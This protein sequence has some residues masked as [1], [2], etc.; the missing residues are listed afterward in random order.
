M[1]TIQPAAPKAPAQCAK[2]YDRSLPEGS[3][4]QTII[5]DRLSF[6]IHKRDF[7]SFQTNVQ[8]MKMKNFHFFTTAFHEAYIPFCLD[9]GPVNLGVV[10]KFCDFMKTKLSKPLLSNR[11]L[12]YCFSADWR[13]ASNACF[14]LAAYLCIEMKSTPEEALRP[15]GGMVKRCTRPFRDA[16]FEP[17]DFL[18]TLEDCI[19]GLTKALQ[20]QWLDPTTFDLHDYAKWDSPRNGDLHQI[21]PKLIAFRGPVTLS[22]T[23]SGG[24]MHEKDLGMPS[25]P[26]EY[27]VQVL[28]NMGV[29]AIVRLTESDTYDAKVFESAGIRV[30]ELFFSD[31]STPAITL[32]DKFL[33]VCDSEPGVVA[34]HCLAGLGRTGTMIG[35]WMIRKYGW[36]AKEAVGWL[37]IVRPGSVIGPQQH[38]LTRVELGS[39]PVDDAEDTTEDDKTGDGVEEDLR[40]KLSM[41]I[42]EG[43]QRKW[44]LDERRKGVWVL[45]V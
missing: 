44:D 3:T 43:M 4:I 7:R 18:L 13:L 21:C 19:R 30:H 32:L 2:H 11:H 17:S 20:Q 24:T 8:R 27:Y 14:L 38:F 42:K 22:R 29:S 10:M 37:R 28:K 12:V 26:P 6:V 9:F 16:T 15:F 35:G 33:E 23:Q 40:A 31:C 25:Q 41:Q 1:R 34:V 45:S 39:F 36:T 5:P